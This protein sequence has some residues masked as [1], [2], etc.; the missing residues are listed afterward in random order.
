MSLLCWIQVL[1]FI[2]FSFDL[3]GSWSFRTNEYDICDPRCETVRTMHS[4]L[5]S[6]N[7]VHVAPP[8][9]PEKT[10]ETAVHRRLVQ[11]RA[12]CFKTLRFERAS[13]CPCTG[14][15]FPVCIFVIFSW[16]LFWPEAHQFDSHRMRF[17]EF[18]FISF[19]AFS[20]WV[21]FF[22]NVCFVFFNW[23]II[24]PSARVFNTWLCTF[25]FHSNFIFHMI[26]LLFHIIHSTLKNHKK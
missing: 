3:L 26:S 20:T 13:D 2:M 22:A 15:I 18:H 8:A 19:P 24:W 12:L 1:M 16:A 23:I 11:A 5:I 14:L 10:V 21:R 7:F 17:C 9:Q 4:L 25:Q 6:G